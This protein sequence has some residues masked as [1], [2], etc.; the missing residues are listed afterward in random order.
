MGIGGGWKASA[1]ASG[2]WGA[3]LGG[4]E[5]FVHGNYGVAMGRRAESFETHCVAIGLDPSK[6]RVARSKQK[7]DFL[8]R[9]LIYQLNTGL[10]DDG[11]ILGQLVINADNVLGFK[12]L[13]DADCSVS[14]RR[15]LALSKEELELLD[16]LEDYEDTIEENEVEIEELKLTIDDL[17]SLLGGQN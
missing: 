11:N 9:S 4:D 17:L 10:T 15:E 1:K 13:A 2:N 12:R 6:D 16:V 5:N 7:G 14:R 3:V 8:V